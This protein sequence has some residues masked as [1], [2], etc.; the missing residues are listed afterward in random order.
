MNML[1]HPMLAVNQDE[2]GN[3]VLAACLP[4]HQQSWHPV[5]WSELLEELAVL[6][7]HP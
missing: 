6:R 7:S 5:A 3:A 2:R 4:R 1:W